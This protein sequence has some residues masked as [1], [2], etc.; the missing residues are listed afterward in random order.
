MAFCIK[1]GTQLADGAR[2]C[3]KCGTPVQAAADMTVINTTSS[4]S[5]APSSGKEIYTLTLKD[6]S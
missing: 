4:V 2:F 5:P 6:G 1:C 3:A